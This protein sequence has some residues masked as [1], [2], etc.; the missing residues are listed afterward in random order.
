MLIATAADL[1]LSPFIWTSHRAIVGDA[2]YA[3]G[4]ITRELLN[5]REQ[6]PDETIVFVIPGDI[7]DSTTPDPYTEKIFK[8][9]INVLRLQKI[10][11]LTIQGNHEYHAKTARATLFDTVPL[12]DT[13]L[14]IDGVKF[15]GIDF[16]ASTEELH[17]KV[18]V[19]P[20]CDYLAMHTSFRHL[21]GFEDKWQIEKDDIPGHIKNVLVGDIH[22][23]SRVTNEEGVHIVSPGSTH[24]RDVA[25]INGGHGVYVFSHEA[26]ITTGEWHNVEPRKFY[27]ASVMDENDLARLRNL[28]VTQTS[29]SGLPSVIILTVVNDLYKQAVVIAEGKGVLVVSKGALRPMMPDEQVAVQTEIPPLPAC[30]PMVL[31]AK[32]EPEPFALLEQLLTTGDPEAVLDAE[33]NKFTGKETV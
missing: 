19:I 9:N 10:H 27:I 6:H 26:G 29:A 23:Q 33:Y 4:L 3:L 13:P 22:K 8:D 1:H 11:V 7:F 17:E 31:N 32:Q 16:T 12:S 21:L 20:E 24:P 5:L 30:L 25:E 28:E 14:I 2:Y 15:C 18:S